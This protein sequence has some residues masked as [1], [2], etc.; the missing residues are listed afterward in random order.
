MIKKEIFYSLL[1]RK[2]SIILDWCYKKNPTGSQVLHFIN[3][4]ILSL[5]LSLSLSGF[6]IINEPFSLFEYWP[7]VLYTLVPKRYL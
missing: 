1:N 4:Q 2:T 7:P 6:E 5:S 3:L